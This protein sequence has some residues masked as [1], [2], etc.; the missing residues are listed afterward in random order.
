MQIQDIPF[1]REGGKV[2]RVEFLINNQPI[3][4]MEI[5]NDETGTAELGNYD[6]TIFEEPSSH[7]YVRIENFD[8]KQGAFA[9]A[10]KCLEEYHVHRD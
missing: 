7:R 4:Y 1:G 8:R 9:L 2:L 5:Y 10:Q 3:G 6:V